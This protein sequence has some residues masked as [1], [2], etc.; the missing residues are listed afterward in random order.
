MCIVAFNA[1]EC[2]ITHETVLEEGHL[3]RAILHVLADGTETELG[4]CY[5]PTN[6]RGSETVQQAMLVTSARKVLDKMACDADEAGRP[7]L[8]AGDIGW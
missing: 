7:L 6:R 4:N 8:I 3:L 5:M 2:A 1:K